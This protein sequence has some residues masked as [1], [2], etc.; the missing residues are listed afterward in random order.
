M[1]EL[2]LVIGEER[3]DFFREETLVTI[4]RSTV[5]KHPNKTALYF[6]GKQI[7]YKILDEWSTNLAYLLQAKGLKQGNPCLVWW[8]RQIL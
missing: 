4:F 1:Q 5:E 6:N 3:Q 2:S 7:S 8:E